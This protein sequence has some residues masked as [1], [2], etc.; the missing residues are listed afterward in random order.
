ML[1]YLNKAIYIGI[2]AVIFLFPAYLIRFSILGVPT[3]AVE[4]LIYFVFLM[5]LVS[6]FLEKDNS[7]LR[8]IKDIVVTNKLL[9]FGLFLFLLGAFASSLMSDDII[10]SLGLFKAY[11]LDTF[12]FLLLFISVISVNNLKYVLLSFTSSGLAVTLVS[13]IYFYKGILTY[14][15][16]LE[17]I[18]NSPN[19]L[20]MSLAPLILVLV[21]VLLNKDIYKKYRVSTFFMLA[22]VSALFLATYSFGAFLAIFIA[23][24]V[25]CV[26]NT[27]STPIRFLILTLAFSLLLSFGGYKFEEIK[28]F[29]NN[30]RS[31]FASREMI[32]DSSYRIL[33]DNYIKGVGPGM[34][35]P[36]Y[37]AYKDTNKSPYLEWAV[38]YPHNIFLAFW[39]QNG[40]LG[41]SGF[42][43]ILFWMLKKV[44]NLR[45][46]NDLSGKIS[47]LV[48]SYFVYLI[49]H[50]MVD[51]PFWKNDLALS[52]F[53]FIA[54][55][56]V[57]SVNKK[58]P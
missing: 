4:S 40:I 20:A 27:S 19:F 14:D 45:N 23:L 30:D 54:L 44:F 50:G 11:F 47:I 48:V 7:K 39:I 38:P 1:A 53:L 9:V 31:S 51:T 17:A 6:L 37:L 16:R 32:W 21:W 3:T 52:F 55:L 57:V 42:I 12:I 5:W 24:V 46:Q 15:G 26:L 8:K 25:L 18:F 58:Y 2:I 10:V 33:K 13:Y 43:V 22:L 29:L 36:E 34:F 56:L 41:F 28:L 49:L 35:Q